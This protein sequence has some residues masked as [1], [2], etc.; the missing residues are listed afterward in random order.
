MWGGSPTEK[1]VSSVAFSVEIL[2]VGPLVGSSS[3]LECIKTRTVG[4]CNLQDQ[5]G[6]IGS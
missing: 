6:G 2:S 3:A 5:E 1:R 4:L